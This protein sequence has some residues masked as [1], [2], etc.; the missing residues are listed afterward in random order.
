[1]KIIMLDLDA[2][3]PDHLGCYG[4]HRQ[5]SPNI[6]KI[7]EKG[8]RFENYY[9]SDAP[10]LPSRTALMSGRFGIKNGVVGHG[11][12]AA[13]L[14]NEG[15]SR[16]FNDQ[17]ATDSIPGM[18]R[19]AGYKTALISPF[20]QRHSAWHFTAGFNEV[21]DV[22]GKNGWES[23]EDVTPTVVDWLTRN[24]DAEN[25]FLYVNYWDVHKPH[26]T[27]AGFANPFEEEPIPDWIT[28][29]VLEIHK[30]KVGPQSVHELDMYHGDYI[31]VFPKF[32]PHIKN[33]AQLKMVIDGYDTSIRYLDEHIGILRQTVADLGIDEEVAFI[34]TSDHGENL[35]E[36][37]IYVEHATA[38]HVTCRVPMIICWPGMGENRV[39][40]GLHYA[41]DLAPTLAQ[42]LNQKKRAGWDGRSY[43]SALTDGIDVG[44][45]FV[46]VSQ[47]AHVV[48]RS[49]RFGD[50]F[51]IR[52][53]HDGFHLFEKEMLFNLADDPHEQ[54]NL[55]SVR[56]DICAQAVYYLSEWHDEMMLTSFDGIDP[57][58]T[59]MKE[60]GPYHTW[61]KLEDYLPRLEA[62]GRGYG[63]DEL[64]RRHPLAFGKNK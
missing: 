30:K 1:M 60:G 46:V 35:G 13:T 45:E 51:Y 62:T 19:G 26:R 58:W 8:V 52:T 37:G 48:Q 49:V 2:L 31:D 64:K 38:D 55:A 42:L 20:P 11:G 40:T 7:A 63:I 29:D 16:D 34:I 28:E 3:R 9:T 32:Q 39:D 44:R 61:G 23:A 21:Y 47:C 54:V 22:G 25:W 6:D 43:L 50:W 41:L 12:T 15:A 10:C 36:L 14:K 33:M 24:K 56:K 53:Y 5:T 59:V 57:L 27:P 18:L 17:L 4:Y